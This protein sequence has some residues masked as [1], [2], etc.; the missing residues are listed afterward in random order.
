M[1]TSPLV[2]DAAQGPRQPAAPLGGH[3]NRVCAVS[4]CR[5]DPSAHPMMFVLALA[6]A[7][8]AYHRVAVCERPRLM[9]RDLAVASSLDFASN[10]LPPSIIHRRLVD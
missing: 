2:E 8:L 6:A 1:T 10:R 5:A 9:H 4:R 7:G 3:R